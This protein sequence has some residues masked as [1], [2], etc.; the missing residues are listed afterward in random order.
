MKK[1]TT[2]FF[3][4]LLIIL[5]QAMILPA[6]AQLALPQPSPRCGARL[7]MGVTDIEVD[8]GSPGVNGRALWGSL[9]PFDEI[10]RSG[11]NAATWISFSTEVQVGG[12][13]LKAGKYALYLIPRAD[14]PWI[15]A[16][17]SNEG[18]WGSTN[19]KES[20]D[21][22][23]TEVQIAPA[24]S[25]AER[26]QYSLEY[27]GMSSAQLRM[28]WGPTTWTLPIQS[29][30]KSL[31]MA[32]VRKF[33]VDRPGDWYPCANAAA[34]V[35]ENGNDPAYALEL[36]QKAVRLN[37]EHFYPRWI[38]ARVHAARAEFRLAADQADQARIKGEA[39]NSDW[40]QGYAGDIAKNMKA[41]NEAAGP[42]VPAGKKRK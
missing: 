23:R 24:P 26:L 11:A 6:A 32:N 3:T 34:F 42:L 1:F 25:F 27:I 7:T 19:F 10:W 38:L 22:L 40:Y 36:A 4:F 39:E 35:L 18:Q 14:K 8:Y 33:F 30:A 5:A 2:P 29:D 31:G 20:L 12:Q 9:V 21:I 28:H 37:G 13:T 17:N 16:L 15:L 41:W